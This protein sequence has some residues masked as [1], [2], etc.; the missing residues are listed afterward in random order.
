MEYLIKASAVVAIFYICY[1]LF[2]QR[3][4]FFQSNRWFL[5]TGLVIAF[6]I[7][8]VIIPVYIKSTP[9]PITE[10]SAYTFSTETT[11]N[12]NSSHEIS[13][14]L[15]L[16]WIYIIGVFFFLIKFCIELASLQ[17]LL[18]SHKTYKE[19]SFKFIETSDNVPPFSFFNW[20]VYNPKKYTKDELSHIITHE[21]V[22]AKE[23][24]S[25]DIILTQLT[26]I[27]LWFNPFIWLYKKDLQQN[28]EFIAD[29]KAQNYSTCDKS[30]QQ[31]LLKSS[32][33]QHAYLLTNNFYNSQI[34]KRIVMLHKSK[35]NRLKVWK[36][37]LILPV[38]ALF[39]MSFNTEEIVIENKITEEQNPVIEAMPIIEKNTI[40]KEKPVKEAKAIKKSKPLTNLTLK[41]EE[42]PEINNGHIAMAMITKN[43]TDA[44]LEVIK[45]TLKKEGLTVKFKG[46][47]RNKKG[48]ITAIKINASSKKSSSNYQVNSDNETIK[49]VKIVFDSEKNSISIG[50]GHNT[51][52]E[53]TFVFQSKDEN[54][55]IHNSGNGNHT[56]VYTTET[57]HEHD[58]EHEHED[59]IIIK[60]AGKKGKVKT[61]K[62]SKN[63]QVISGDNNKTVEII[64]DED[65][66]NEETIIVNGKK[67]NIEE[68]EQHI[69]IKAKAK[70]VWVSEDASNEDIIAI[71]NNNSKNNV[72]IL[73][74]TDKEPLVI[75]NGK[76]ITK[77]Q[78]LDIEPAM[79][80]SIS[81]LT[82]KKATE[83]YGKKGENGVIIIKLKKKN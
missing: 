55:K 22:H 68:G 9:A 1:K 49:P 33:S 82:D 72:F 34:K 16:T 36:Y 63:V 79:I 4:T 40:P 41:E 29:Q 60:R 44:E 25:L 47:K 53:N 12:T 54:H 62:R 38:L 31:V 24:H 57:Q 48:E 42:K 11:G 15:L 35:S 45:E 39:L 10:I 7:P 58:D 70:S 46:V 28:L 59:K 74:D 23:L 80:E 19:N 20:I 14:V 71:Q 66:D 83:K 3:E 65:N 73:K 2:L 18:K 61:I 5:L 51:H 50:N 76:E 69:I 67:V 8:F 78:M 17:F 30:Y 26:C 75:V 32:V 56:F 64:I 77:D 21:K 13:I 27:I 6:S 43:T 81:F 52:G 37:S